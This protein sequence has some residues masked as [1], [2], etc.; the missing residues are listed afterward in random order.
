MSLAPAPFF[1]LGIQLCGIVE[2]QPSALCPW[3]NKPKGT[4]KNFQGGRVKEI[5]WAAIATMG[6]LFCKIIEHL[7]QLN[8]CESSILLLE[9]ECIWNLYLCST[10]HGTALLDA[11]CDKILETPEQLP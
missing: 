4:Q 7:Y 9:A 11:Y 5:A 3:E 10:A 6:F 1:I 8:H 2:L